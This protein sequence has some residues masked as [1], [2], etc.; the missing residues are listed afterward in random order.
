MASRRS[1]DFDVGTHIFCQRGLQEDEIVEEFDS[2]SGVG[3]EGH[4]G[5]YK[6]EDRREG[7]IMSEH[8]PRL[9]TV[10]LVSL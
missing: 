4:C 7:V 9:Y 1:D 8:R 10:R 2:N 3:L 5:A 6:M